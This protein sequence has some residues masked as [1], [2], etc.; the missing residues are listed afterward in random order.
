MRLMLKSKYRD[1]EL[2]I[3][4]LKGSWF[5]TEV[6]S[7]ATA[8]LMVKKLTECMQQLLHTLHFDTG[9]LEIITRLRGAQ[10]ELL[11]DNKRLK[12]TDIWAEGY[13]VEREDEYDH[14][15]I[16]LGTWTRLTMVKVRDYHW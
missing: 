10:E 3:D 7:Y 6:K 14:V 2:E 1:M 16:C 11:S 13:G 4:K 9:V 15:N 8:P 5:V 12:K